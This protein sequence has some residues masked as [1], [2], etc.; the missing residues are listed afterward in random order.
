M[1]TI[2]DRRP[3]GRYQEIPEGAYSREQI[4]EAW[5]LKRTRTTDLLKEGV[6]QGKFER[7]E[8]LR[9]GSIRAYYRL[10]KDTPQ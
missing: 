5:G 10:V 6:E 8:V 3:S 4:Q 2:L 7:L 9:D 1:G